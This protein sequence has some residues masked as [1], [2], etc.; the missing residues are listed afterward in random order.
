MKFEEALIKCCGSFPRNLIHVAHI[1]TLKVEQLQ[2]A[3]VIYHGVWSGPS[4][5]SIR[6]LFA[7]LARFSNPPMFLTQ[8]IV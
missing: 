7:V 5:A 4:V 2:Q 1:D 6:L 3:I 8:M